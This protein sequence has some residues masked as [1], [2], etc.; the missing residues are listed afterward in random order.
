[1]ADTGAVVCWP[2]VTAGGEG[3]HPILIAIV[4]GLISSWIWKVIQP[5]WWDGQLM[6]FITGHCDAR[7]MYAQLTISNGKLVDWACLE[8]N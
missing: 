5:G 8:P 7:G 4:S 3:E 1:M 6:E 2:V